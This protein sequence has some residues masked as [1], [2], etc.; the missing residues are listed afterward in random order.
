MTPYQA[1]IASCDAA[2]QAYSKDPTPAN[3]Q[4]FRKRYGEKVDAERHERL[5]KR[6][7]LHD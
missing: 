1:A 7:I 6:A 4:Q 3:H 2:W 5:A